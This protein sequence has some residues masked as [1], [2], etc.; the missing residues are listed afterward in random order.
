MTPPPEQRSVKIGADERTGWSSDR[1]RRDGTAP[2]PREVDVSTRCRV[3]RPSDRLR[4]SPGSLV[5]LVSPSI[6]ERGRFADRVL[7]DKRALLSSAKVRTLLQ[8]RVAEEEMGDK[9]AELLG[10]AVAKRLDAGDSVVL[11][12][13]SLDPAER[14]PF[15]RMAHALR[16]PRHL[17]LL[18]TPREQVADDD[19]QPL[20]DL[21]KA[22]DAGEVGEEGFQ[23]ALRLGGGT[24]AEVK[25]LVFRPPPADD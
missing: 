16:R 10:V 9:V 19:R 1:P 3:L 23:T 7:E 15:V 14:A 25:K 21:R 6:A 22:L 13:E 12:A 5:V 24:I 20:N 17:V 8:G 18:E 11:A 2:K 4:Y